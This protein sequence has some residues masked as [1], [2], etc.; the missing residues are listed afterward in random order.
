MKILPLPRAYQDYIGLKNTL[1]KKVKENGIS[2]SENE[3]P[4]LNRKLY[5]LA[6]K[7][8]IIGIGWA[9]KVNI[10]ARGILAISTYLGSQDFADGKQIS[11][12]NIVKREYHHIFPDALLQ[13]A[14]IE[15]F[16]ALNCALI[17]GKTNRNIGRKDPLIYGYVTVKCGILK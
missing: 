17:T 13:E 6:D 14:N 16:L 4:V 9:K 2:F 3:I 5:P 11:R 1:C 7:E 12:E 8:E 15:S 10:R